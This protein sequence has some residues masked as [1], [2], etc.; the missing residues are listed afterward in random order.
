MDNKPSLDLFE[1]AKP[2][3]QRGS[4]GDRFT[5]SA[6]SSEKYGFIK[7]DARYATS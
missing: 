5:Q 2:R 3:V 7:K 6:T 1:I 4:V